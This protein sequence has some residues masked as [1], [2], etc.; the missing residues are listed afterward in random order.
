MAYVIKVMV[1]DRKTGRGLSG[2]KVKTYGG[3]ETKTDSS[4]HATVVANSSSVEVY[5]N[6]SRA[7]SGSSISAPKPII[8]EKG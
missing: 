5:V 6:G 4:G 2:E 3:A 7:Y 1:V 8:Y